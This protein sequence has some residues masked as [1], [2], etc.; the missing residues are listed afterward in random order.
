MRA[1]EL[2]PLV[3]QRERFPEARQRDFVR[4]WVELLDTFNQQFRRHCRAQMPQGVGVNVAPF[5]FDTQYRPSIPWDYS[6]WLGD[7]NCFGMYFW[8]LAT[9]WPSRRRCT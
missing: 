7:V 2:A 4:F 5:S 1:V 6:K 9:S 8:G 3:D